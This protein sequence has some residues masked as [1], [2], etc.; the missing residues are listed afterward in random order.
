MSQLILSKMEYRYPQYALVTIEE[1]P[2]VLYGIKISHNMQFT[3]RRVAFCTHDGDFIPFLCHISNYQCVTHALYLSSWIHQHIAWLDFTNR[4]RL[5]FMANG[6]SAAHLIGMLQK[7]LQCRI[8]IPE[9]TRSIFRGCSQQP[10]GV[11]MPLFDV[12]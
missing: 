3:G 1:E 8:H 5:R 4:T 12:R 6:K 9:H 11:K 7:H 10:E 2:G